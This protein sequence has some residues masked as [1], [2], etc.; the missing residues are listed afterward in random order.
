MIYLH[1]G[2]INKAKLLVDSIDI[3]QCGQRERAA[4][5]NMYR[6]FYLK[7]GD[8]KNAYDYLDSII[9]IQN[10]ITWDIMDNNIALAQKGYYDNK[11]VESLK[12]RV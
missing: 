1:E 8:Y 7:L 10:K 11:S 3:N 9:H 5:Y 12:K 4:F 2:K 6:Q